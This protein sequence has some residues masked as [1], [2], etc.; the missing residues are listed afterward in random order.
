MEKTIA[1]VIIFLF[2]M[3]SFTSISGNQINENIVNPSDKGI[4]LYVGGSGEGNYSKIQDAIDNASDGDTVF[5]YDDNSPYEEN[6]IVNKSIKLIGENRNTTFINGSYYGDVIYISANSTTI[7]GFT[8]QN[9]GYA[10]AGIYISSNYNTITGN[11][12]IDHGYSWWVKI[13]IY[14]SY[15]DGNTISDNK[16]SMNLYSYGDDVIGIFLDGSNNNVIAG[17]NISNNW[18]YHDGFGIYIYNS[19][20]NTITDNIISENSIGIWLY[21]STKNNISSNLI[22]S[23]HYG[24]GFRES[25][26]SEISNNSFL[27]N[28]RGIHLYEAYNINIFDNSFFKGGLYVSNSE[29]NNVENNTVN[30]K[31]LVYLENKSNKVVNEAGQAILVNCDNINVTNL[32]LSDTTYA[33]QLWRT[34]NSN[35]CNNYFSNVRY[36]IHSSYSHNNNLS[37]NNFLK[38]AMG[39][40]LFA[41]NGTII[42]SNTFSSGNLSTGMS[43]SESSNNIICNNNILVKTG[44]IHLRY[45]INFSIINNNIDLNNDHKPKVIKG[46]YLWCCDN[47]IITDNIICTRYSQG[48]GILITHSN[49]NFISSNEISKIGIGDYGWGI[50]LLYSDLNIITLNNIK[51]ACGGI[52]LSNSFENIIIAN[53]VF[54]NRCDGIHFK[55]SIN[56]TISNNTIIKNP[57]GIILDPYSHNNTFYHNNF[58]DNIDNAYDEGNNTW[59]DGYPSGGNY[60]DDYNGT[61]NDGDGIG[62][63]PYPI[64]GGDNEDRYPLMEPYGNHPPNTPTING[65]ISGKPNIEYDFTF[66][67][68]DPDRDII[69][70]VIDWGDNITEWTDYV[71]SGMEIL[72]NHTWNET[73]VYTIKAQA[74]DI[75]GAVSDW[76]TLVVTIPRNKATSNILFQGLKYNYQVYNKYYPSKGGI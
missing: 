17:N 27:D 64:P 72:L 13:G 65:P 31:P 44:G 42:D 18:G 39:M 26:N 11:N 54:E 61:D 1:L 36:G 33:V 29:D 47:N 25:N 52:R 19:S 71:D 57:T 70:Y 69:M 46:I 76:G 5:V 34:N 15:S 56:N 58:I 32:I 60:W 63:T 7:T 75:Y 30:G 16:V 3:M 35:I 62:D 43:I 73:G 38:N 10:G 2:V 20:N 74:I 40:Y 67:A 45:C 23:N 37:N 4:I 14:L 28:Y 59:D 66:N 49:N 51:K 41:S 12:I 48:D 9:I 68:T 8:I 55:K 24:I 53:N 21:K 50:Y 6:P 22:F